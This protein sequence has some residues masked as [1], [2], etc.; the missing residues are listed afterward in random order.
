MAESSP[1]QTADYI[2]TVSGDELGPQIFLGEHEPLEFRFIP[3]SSHQ[4]RGWGKPDGPC[5]FWTSSPT[6]QISG[7]AEW[8]AS[9]SFATGIQHSWKL[10]PSPDA[11]IA[12]IDSYEDLRRLHLLYG[13]SDDWAKYWLDFSLV[14]ERFA[15]I[16]LTD[17]GQWAT[18]L[19]HPYGLYGWDCEST[20]WLQW[21][22][23]KVEDCGLVT[24]GRDE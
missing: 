4:D 9:E 24:V 18:R 6:T 23:V 22:F 20:L 21:S 17:E 10:T 7:W 11:Q 8:R 15:G 5:G 2:R 3:V 12:Q 19:T 13:R 1:I 16:N 14:A